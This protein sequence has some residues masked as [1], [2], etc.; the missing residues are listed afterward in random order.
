MIRSLDQLADYESFT[1]DV[2][3][4]LREA[5]Q[6]GWTAEEIQNDPRV[7]AALV[8]RQI[9]IALRE[10]DPGKAHVAIKDLR[11]RIDGKPKESKDIN[12]KYEDMS[13]DEIQSKLNQ[14]MGA[15]EGGGDVIPDSDELN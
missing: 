12:V 8:A 14:L 10:A 4:I 15:E 3:P 1:S 11:D 9:S 6:K 5:I 2:L 13:D 7:K